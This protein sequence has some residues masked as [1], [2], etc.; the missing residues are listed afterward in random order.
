MFGS[1]LK[2]LFTYT[3]NFIYLDYNFCGFCDFYWTLW[4]IT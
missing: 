3:I 4:M 2:G 1:G